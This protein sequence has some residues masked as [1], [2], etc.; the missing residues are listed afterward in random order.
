MSSA[1]NSL[2]PVLLNIL[3]YCCYCFDSICS[4]FVFLMESPIIFPITCHPHHCSWSVCF[5]QLR[6]GNISLLLSYYS[7]PLLCFPCISFHFNTTALKE[8]IAAWLVLKSDHS[9]RKTTINEKKVND[10]CWLKCLNSC[11]NLEHWPGTKIHI[12]SCWLVYKYLSKYFQTNPHTSET[13][14]PAGTETA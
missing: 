2:S 10:W 13:S 9:R 14:E 11:K 6:P 7:V 1:T 4:S 3:C 12:M 8:V 5:W